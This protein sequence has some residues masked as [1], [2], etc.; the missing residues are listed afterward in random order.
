MRLTILFILIL[1]ASFKG[2]TQSCPEGKLPFPVGMFYK[3]N[4]DGQT[5]P[6]KI[7]RAALCADNPRLVAIALNITLGMFGM[8]RLYLGTD[9][10]IPIFYTVTLGG[11]LVLW[12]VDLALLIAAED[13]SPFMDNPNFFMWNDAK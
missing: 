6:R 2:L 8:H 13:I 7:M 11:G 9:V 1:C 3:I 5:Q 4:D 10:K 12:V